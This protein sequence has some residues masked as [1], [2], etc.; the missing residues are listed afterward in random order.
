M[1]MVKVINR[2]YTKPIILNQ[3]LGAT[4]NDLLHVYG[5]KSNV[6]GHL[7]FLLGQA[8]LPSMR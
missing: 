2:N 3:A 6:F 1:N 4:E 8:D 5:K 7:P